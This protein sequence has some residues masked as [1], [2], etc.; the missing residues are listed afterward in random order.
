MKLLEVTCCCWNMK[1]AW[2]STKWA[3]MPYLHCSPYWENK[4]HWDMEKR[5][6]YSQSIKIYLSYNG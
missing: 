3:K 1:M 2:D 5:E 4:I 6:E